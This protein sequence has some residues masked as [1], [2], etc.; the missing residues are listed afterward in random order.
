MRYT[1]RDDGIE[2]GPVVEIIVMMLMPMMMLLMMMLQIILHDFGGTIQATFNRFDM[3]QQ[4]R[5][6]CG[7]AWMVMDRI[8]FRSC[9]C[10]RCKESGLLLLL[11]LRTMMMMKLRRLLPPRSR[12]VI[13]TGDTDRWRSTTCHTAFRD[14][15]SGS[16]RTTTTATCQCCRR[17]MNDRS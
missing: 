15:S 8:L 16:M 1:R 12:T 4:H 7:A 11:R 13:V 10:C 9:H 14:S 6:W 3:E 5:W 2:F 17:A